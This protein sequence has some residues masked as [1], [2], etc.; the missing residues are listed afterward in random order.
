MP[1]RR[2]GKGWEVRVQSA[3]ARVSKTFRSRQD[4]FEYERIVR[5]RNNDSQLGRAP[6]YSLEEALERWLTGEAVNLK[7]FDSIKEKVRQIYPHVRGRAL[8][9]VVEVAEAVKSAGIARG[10]L[11]A[12]INRRLAVL[13]RVANLA[14][15][16]WNWLD[17][18]LGDRVR[19][20]P[21]ER[22]RHI[23]LTPEQVKTLAAAA[24]GRVGDAIILAA[25][26]GLRRGE[27]LALKPENRRDGMLTLTET[28][29]GRPRIVPLPPEARDI[30]LPLDLTAA[31]FRF[32]FEA[33]REATG[34]NVRAH[35]LRHTYA[36]WLVQSGA[37]LTVV[38][39]LLGHSSLAVTSRYSHLMT[40][41]LVR[42]VERMAKATKRRI[43][44]KKKAA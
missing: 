19:L 13:R 20:L 43:T 32:G 40:G 12:T 23:Y 7:S 34:L 14:Y 22:A 35:D 38:R 37:G 33:A 3:Y 28:K 26:S 31:Q 36:S 8:A 9:D 15:R 41:D 16:Q 18:P 27:L 30:R 5:A 21:G 39:D 4:A 11:P 6:R 10:S 1:I 44:S 17:K 29:N 2:H 25:C 24:P 42:A